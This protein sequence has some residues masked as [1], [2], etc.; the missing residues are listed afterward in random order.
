MSP[1]AP[2]YVPEC[3][4]QDTTKSIIDENGSYDFTRFSRHET[5]IIQKVIK[6]TLRKYPADYFSVGLAN[7]S[8]AI[9]YK[10]RYILLDIIVAAFENSSNI[11]DQ[12]AVAISYAKQGA[13]YRNEAI[14]YFEMTFDAISPEFMQQFS[15]LS[16][17]SVYSMF[18]EIYEKEHLFEKAI[19]MT[20]LAWKYANQNNEFFP[21]RI[22]DLDK[23]ILNPPKTRKRRISDQQITMSESIRRASLE[24]VTSY[25][26]LVGK[27]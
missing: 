10:P 14:R 3:Y 22:S 12:F 23:K 2:T 8:L 25:D 21:S 27:K 11:Y 16:P 1:S 24:I 4:K 26:E 17:L 19:D 7:E 18:S 9:I 13:Q 6:T 20:K 5:S 15:S